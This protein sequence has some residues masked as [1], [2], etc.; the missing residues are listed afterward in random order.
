MTPIFDQLS[1]EFNYGSYWSSYYKTIQ[2]GMTL[3]IWRK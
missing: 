2:H 1:R 3:R